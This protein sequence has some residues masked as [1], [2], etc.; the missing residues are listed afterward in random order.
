[1]FLDRNLLVSALTYPYTS[2]CNQ[3]MKKWNL[4]LMANWQFWLLYPTSISCSVRSHFMFDRKPFYLYGI[5]SASLSPII[6]NFKLLK[7]CLLDRLANWTL[8]HGA[9]CDYSIKCSCS[10]RSWNLMFVY[11]VFRDRE[12]AVAFASYDLLLGKHLD[13]SMHAWTRIASC[14]KDYYYY[15]T[16]KSKISPILVKKSIF[17]FWDLI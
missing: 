7:L 16:F 13:P 14:S 17:Y 6:A 15:V 1:M 8:C 4:R 9:T 3:L 10:Q 2:W 12:S 5:H 11:T